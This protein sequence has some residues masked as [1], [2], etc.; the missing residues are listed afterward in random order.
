M[1]IVAWN[2]AHQEFGKT[3]YEKVLSPEGAFNTRL[4][5]STERLVNA[6][7]TLKA[8]VAFLN[9][10]HR[11]TSQQDDEDI[12]F[13]GAGYKVARTAVI[14]RRPE[15]SRT[16]DNQT[17]VAAREPI[18]FLDS[19]SHAPP[20]CALD[21]YCH[22]KNSGTDIVGLRIPAYQGDTRDKDN[23]DHLIWLE[24]TI[25]PLVKSRSII[26]GDV[27]RD[28][29]DVEQSEF[30]TRMQDAGWRTIR[31]LGHPWSFRNRNERK[32]GK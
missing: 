14:P 19:A 16:R 9:E 1:R 6:I 31:P 4:I 18:T 29:D 3:K 12:Q 8:D 7:V 5:V 26:L 11:S 20:D 28:P 17:L 10:Y 22:I 15:Q 25:K 21:N 2:V 32:N 23:E 30:F 24:R 27:N 13:D